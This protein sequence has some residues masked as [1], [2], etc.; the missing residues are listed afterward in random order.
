MPTT[1][2]STPDFILKA[3]ESVANVSNTLLAKIEELQKTCKVAIRVVNNA[4]LVFYPIGATLYLISNTRL[5]CNGVI[6]DRGTS[7][8]IQENIFLDDCVMMK[9]LVKL[10][11]DFVVFEELLHDLEETWSLDPP[12]TI[13]DRLSDPV[14]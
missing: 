4:T 5:D 3:A 12:L 11:T 9:I 7:G 14:V 1:D 6:L 8:I 13:A 10:E 2:L